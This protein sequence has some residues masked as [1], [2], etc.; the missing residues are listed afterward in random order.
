M[1]FHYVMCLL[2]SGI[3]FSY[4]LYAAYEKETVTPKFPAVRHDMAKY[5]F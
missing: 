3:Y 4:Q 5:I 2:E 1:Q